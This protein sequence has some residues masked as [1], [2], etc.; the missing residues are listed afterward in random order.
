LRELD[1]TPGAEEVAE[2]PGSAGPIDSGAATVWK[3]STPARPAMLLTTTIGARLIWPGS[4]VERRC[5]AFWRSASSLGTRPYGQMK[6]STEVSDEASQSADRGRRR[7]IGGSRHING[8]SRQFR[9][10]PLRSW[11]MRADQFAAERAQP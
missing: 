10:L 1:A 9:E 7:A 8:E 5:S 3:P 4:G 6:L 2:V 11:R